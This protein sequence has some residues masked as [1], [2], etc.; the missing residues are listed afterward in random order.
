MQI[1]HCIR[2]DNVVV[3]DNALLGMGIDLI[4]LQVLIQNREQ[5]SQKKRSRFLNEGGWGV[6]LVFGCGVWCEYLHWRRERGPM[7]TEY[8]VLSWYSPISWP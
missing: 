1:T 6:W 7:S 8:F 3:N 2:W 5:G 4:T